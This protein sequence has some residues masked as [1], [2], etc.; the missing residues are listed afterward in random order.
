MVKKIKENK[1]VMIIVWLLMLVGIILLLMSNGKRRLEVIKQVELTSG[2]KS[3]ENKEDGSWNLTKTAKWIDFRKARIE[4]NFDSIASNFKEYQ[5]IYLVIDLSASMKGKKLEKVQSDTKALVEA[6]LSEN[7]D[8]RIG[9]IVFSSQSGIETDLTSSKT[10]L[11]EIID[12][13]DWYDSTNYYAA[14][15][16]VEE[17]LHDYNYNDDREVIVLF[18]TDGRPSNYGDNSSVYHEIKEIY[19]FVNIIG[20]QYEM[21]DQI[22]EPIIKISDYQYSAYMTDLKNVLFEATNSTGM[23]ENVEI[24][25]YI[26][27]D[28]KVDSV[29]DITPSVGYVKL[30]DDNGRQ[31]VIWTIPKDTLRIGKNA[32]LKIDATLQEVSYDK[33]YVITN[34]KEE[35]TVKI[36]DEDI[37]TQKTTIRPTLKNASKVIYKGNSPSDCNVSAI[38][39][40]KFYA[41]FEPVSIEEGAKCNG[42]NFKKWSIDNDNI[43]FV[44]KNTFLMPDEDVQLTAVWGKFDLSKSMDGKVE[45]LSGAGYLVEKANKFSSKTDYERGE[46]QQMYMFEHDATD[47]T[48]ALTD[49]RYVWYSPKNFL[50]FNCTNEN[51]RSTCEMWRI[52]G[53]FDVE[54][55][56]PNDESKKIVEQRIKIIKNNKFSNSMNWADQS[57]IIDWKDASLNDYLNGTYYDS[58]S[59]VAKSQIDDA[60]YYLGEI[61]PGNPNSLSIEEL[62]ASER[63]N[64]KCFEDKKLNW[65][66]K[67]ALIYPSDFYMTRVICADSEFCYQRDYPTWIEIGNWDSY[68]QASTW[69]LTQNSNGQPIYWSKSGYMDSRFPDSWKYVRPTLY[70]KAGVQI[71]DG[72]GSYSNPY[73]LE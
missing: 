36:P 55:T 61:R 20:I 41:P 22:V 14:L 10:K 6:K 48:E 15:Q 57:S 21:G 59:D 54:R 46:K 69:F 29:E 32:N 28:F 34:E 18:L 7:P 24:I 56:D 39:D 73:V 66:G 8:N 51:D 52:I 40:T 19:P 9:I 17:S 2:R 12:S 11:F 68:N 1:K 63:S 33:E 26:H 23:F 30:E 4:F 50:Y 53:V 62:Y 35:I 37:E 45:T 65:E 60:I 5:D 72:D 47:Q 64:L 27:E 16:N 42:Y 49:Y 38:P 25:D 43:I 70:L 13:F 3:Y 67:I 44:N 71:V 58:L 31:K